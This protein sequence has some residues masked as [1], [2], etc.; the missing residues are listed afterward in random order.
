MGEG[1]I[2]TDV[3]GKVIM[4]NSEAE[5]LTGWSSKEAIGQP[6]KSVFDVTVDL[7]AQAKVQKSGYRSEAQSILL[8]LPENVTL[9]SRDGNERV[10]EQVASPIRDNKN[11]VAGVVLVFRDITARQRADAERRKAETL[12]QLGLLA[13]GI[14]PD[15]TNLLTAIIGNISLASLLLPPDDEMAAR[16]VDAKNASVRAADNAKLLLTLL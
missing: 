5:K 15:F 6:L 16:L 1:F 12:E 13:G 2:T 10:I 4:L 11:E 9:T 3:N 8:N 14:A 7:A